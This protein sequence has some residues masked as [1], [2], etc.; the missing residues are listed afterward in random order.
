MQAM[1]EA[2]TTGKATKV[3]DILARYGLGDLANS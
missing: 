1:D 2:A 3:A